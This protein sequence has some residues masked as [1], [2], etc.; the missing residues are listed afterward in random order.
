MSTDTSLTL[1]AFDYGL[2]RI[3]VASGQT[4]IGTSAP[5]TTVSAR[6]GKPDWSQIERLFQDWRPDQVIVGLPTHADGRKH[7][8]HEPIHKFVRQL[9]GRF[10]VPISLIDEHLS[11]VEAED[12]GATPG[13]LDAAAACIILDTWLNEFR[14]EKRKSDD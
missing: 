12:R 6:D 9:E 8:L 14:R 1:L 11:S 5:L 4:L 13:A 3:G 7:P 2:R 10:N